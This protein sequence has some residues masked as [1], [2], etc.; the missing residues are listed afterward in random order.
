MPSFTLCLLQRTSEDA[1]SLGRSLVATRKF[2]RD[3]ALTWDD[4]DVDRTTTLYALHQEQARLFV[5]CGS[6]LIR[7]HKLNCYGTSLDHP[8]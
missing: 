7:L 8:L 1:G 4:V 6:R 3:H 5:R 2:H